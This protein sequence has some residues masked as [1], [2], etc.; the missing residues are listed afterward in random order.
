MQ[1]AHNAITGHAFII[2]NK[3]NSVSKDRY[4]F[5]VKLSLRKTLKEIASFISENFWFY[6][7]NTFNDCFDY[8]HLLLYFEHELLE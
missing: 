1:S 2:L 7:Q 3:V 4:Y 8:F 6:Y 5:L